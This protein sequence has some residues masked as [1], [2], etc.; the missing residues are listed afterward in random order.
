MSESSEPQQCEPKDD[1][2]II[3][4]TPNKLWT[5]FAIVWV[6]SLLVSGGVSWYAAG[7]EADRSNSAIAKASKD[8]LGIIYTSDT[9]RCLTAV[10]TRQIAIHNAILQQKIQP[11]VQVPK[12]LTPCAISVR[13]PNAAGSVPS[14]VGKAATVRG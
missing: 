14:Q 5:I 8:G 11:S 12:P 10:G 6:I 1:R 13:N 3:H 2:N 7:I 4:I 9:K